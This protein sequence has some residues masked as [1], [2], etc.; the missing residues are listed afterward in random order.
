MK[1]RLLDCGRVDWICQVRCV[2]VMVFVPGVPK[3]GIGGI[4]VCGLGVATGMCPGAV[5][6]GA[7][8][9]APQVD[10]WVAQSSVAANPRVGEPAGW[11]RAPLLVR[12]PKSSGEAF[13]GRSLTSGGPKNKR[14][15]RMGRSPPAGAEP[16][17]GLG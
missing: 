5:P 9:V 8:C 17:S 14:I 7:R 15:R 10:Q 12:G 3:G 6:Q 11:D 13:V 4:P 16:S 2:L 1:L